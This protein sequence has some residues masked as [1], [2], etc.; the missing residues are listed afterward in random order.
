MT[1]IAAD[2]EV[3]PITKA[4]TKAYKPRISSQWL[5]RLEIT[6]LAGPALVVFSL[7]VIIPVIMAAYYGFFK[8]KGLGAPTNFIG[9]DNY[10]DIITDSTFRAAVGHNFFVVLFSLLMQGPLAILFALLMNQKIRGRS[11]IRVLIFVPYVVSEVIAG[12]GWQLMSSDTGA[13]NGLL[14]KM[15]L[16]SWQ[17]SWLANPEIAKWT[18]MIILTWKYVGFAVILMLAGLQSIPEE[19]YEAAAIDGATFWQQQFRITLP[20]L[21]PTIRIW[22]FLSIIG[23]LQ[24]FDVVNIV[25]GQ[26]I[27]NTA[28]TS[29]MATYMYLNGH[30]AGNYGFGSAAAVIMFLISLAVAL[31]YQRFVL[32]R[33]TDGAITGE[34]NKDKRKKKGGK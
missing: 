30:M 27:S 14:A 16:E 4:P 5:K 18:L 3:R 1:A 8:W 21:G 20:L 24:L 17:Q 33:D 26:Y 13:I 2:A 9:F 23:A 7:F 10:I 31:L 25:W 12:T 11:L 19:L 15:G 34:S 28:G 6:I 29:T 32:N 22:C